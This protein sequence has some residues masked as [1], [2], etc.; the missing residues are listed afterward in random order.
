[1]TCGTDRQI[2]LNALE[3]QLISNL[4]MMD[5]VKAEHTL[6]LSINRDGNN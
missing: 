2:A 3:N 6:S 4:P 1:M 5:L